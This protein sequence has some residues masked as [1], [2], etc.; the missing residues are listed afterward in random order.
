MTNTQVVL[1]IIGANAA[2]TTLIIGLFSF[3]INKRFDDLIN[4]VDKKFTD[5]YAHINHRFD[6]LEKRKS[7]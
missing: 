4:H 2:I 3:M 7:A 1:S 5:S 6:Q